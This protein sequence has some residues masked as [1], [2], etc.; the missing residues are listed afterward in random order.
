MEETAL[1]LGGV[2][3]PWDIDRPAGSD[4][5]NPLALI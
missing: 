1:A 5:S 2:L 4:A 3:D